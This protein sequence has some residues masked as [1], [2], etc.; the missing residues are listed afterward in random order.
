M[1]A[2]DQATLIRLGQPPS[3]ILAAACH[4]CNPSAE[5]FGHFLSWRTD[6]FKQLL[7][8]YAEKIQA[9]EL[10]DIESAMLNVLAVIAAGSCPTLVSLVHGSAFVFMTHLHIYT[11]R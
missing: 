5:D 3:Q 8:S 7:V 1:Q 10:D 9:L 2:E 6:V 4:W 11:A